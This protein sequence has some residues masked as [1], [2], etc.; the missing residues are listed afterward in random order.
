MKNSRTVSFHRQYNAYTGGHQKVRDYIAHILT[1]KNFKPILHLE[2]KSVIQSQL[3]TNIEGVSY[4]SVYQPNQ[5]DIVFLAGMDWNAYLPHFDESK[6][7]INLIQHVRHGD[8]SHA[9]FKF[10]KHK[11]IR[12]CVSDAVKNAIEPYANGPCLSIKMGHRIPKIQT[13]KIYDLYILGTKQ[14]ELAVQLAK[15][16]ELKGLN[17]LSH[18][19][20]QEQSQVYTAMAQ[21]RVAIVLPNKTEGFYLPG[22]EAMALA[23]W[24]IVPDCVASREYSLD[25]ANITMCSLDF[26]ACISAIE[27]S[28]IKLGKWNVWYKRWQG[29]KISSSYDLMAERQS[30]TNVM[31]S[32]YKLW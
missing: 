12:V 22:I 9:L 31:S 30:F 6:P 13:T 2:G 15:W 14:P 25:K 26:Q 32:I 20:P 23:N 21:S 11:A 7:K 10:L 28:F 18:D 5:A 24:V 27:S 8:K 1:A 3:F 29:Q 4:Q 19:K 17:V 16:G